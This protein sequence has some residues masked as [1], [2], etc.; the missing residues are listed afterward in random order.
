MKYVP[1]ETS[2]YGGFS[3]QSGLIIS[4]YHISKLW[5]SLDIIGYLSTPE[6]YLYVNDPG[7]P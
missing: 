3:S 2:I 1:I 7:N 6:K 5:I 4:I